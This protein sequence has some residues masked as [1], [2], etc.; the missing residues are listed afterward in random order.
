MLSDQGTSQ[1]ASAYQE[2]MALA[3]SGGGSRAMAFHLGC[4]RGLHKA[5]ILDR[6]DTLTAVSGG[7]VLAAIYCS[8]GGNFTEFE[9]KTR[10]VLRR[11]FVWPSIR[12]ALTTLEGVRALLNFLLVVGDRFAALLFRAVIRPIRKLLPEWGWEWL[13]RSG[14]VRRH[15]RTTILRE[16]FDV[17]LSRRKLMDLRSDRPRLIII[18][19]EL[20]AKAAFYFTAERL[21]CWRYGAASSAGVQLADAVSASAAYPLLLPALDQ[22]LEF[23]KGG[24]T[25]RHRVSLTDGGVYDN[26]GLAPLWPG[27]DPQVSLETGSFQRIIACRAGY[28]NQVSD[29]SSTWPARMKASFLSVLARNENGALNR[30]FDLHKAGGVEAILVPYL[31]QQDSILLHPPADL[32]TRE[33]VANYPTDFSAMSDEWIDKL[34]LRGEQLVSAL[35]KEHWSDLSH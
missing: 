26:L 6:V 10:E 11:G 8:H 19:C 17:M 2:R 21:H 22:V 33:E 25:A 34:S 12:S 31:D 27:R 7:S 28:G 16:A 35:L 13:K 23:D 24:V 3:L 20:R 1:P 14:I 32:V 29:P 4:L 18:A 5:G 15:S 9:A 30:L